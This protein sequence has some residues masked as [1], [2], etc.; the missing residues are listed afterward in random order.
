MRPA[1][2]AA[3]VA[4][5]FTWGGSWNDAKDYMHFEKGAVGP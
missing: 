2:R 4:A 1:W 5:G 3:L